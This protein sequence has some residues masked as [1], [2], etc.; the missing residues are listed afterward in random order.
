MLAFVF[1]FSACGNTK[2][3][4]DKDGTETKENGENKGQGSE[5]ETDADSQSDPAEVLKAVFRAAKS[6]DYRG[7]AALCSGEGDGDVKRI[8]D[9]ENQPEAK[10]E[11]FKSY[12]ET[13]KIVGEPQIEGSEAKVKFTFGP[14]G[15]KNEEM[16]LVKKDGKWYLSSFWD[17]V[18]P[19]K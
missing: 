17:D 8:C 3:E 15:T 14:D 9:I 13:G 6:G 11:E 16:N 12:F 4:K 18:Y 5:D 2:S 7:L 1:I 19:E 10:Q